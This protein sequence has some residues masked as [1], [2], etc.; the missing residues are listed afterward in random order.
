MFLA[1]THTMTI[2]EKYLVRFLLWESATSW[3][4]RA[5]LVRRVKPSAQIF[6]NLN[7]FTSTQGALWQK[8]NTHNLGQN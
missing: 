4:D 6:N 1:F 5:E 7:I 8:R 2:E 3:A